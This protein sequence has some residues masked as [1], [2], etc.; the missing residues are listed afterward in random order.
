VEV[1][2]NLK[3]WKVHHVRRNLNRAAYRLANKAL[4]FS[5]I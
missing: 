4:F 3:I 1:I 5:D 2:H